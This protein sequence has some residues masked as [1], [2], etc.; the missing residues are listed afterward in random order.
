M[1]PRNRLLVDPEVQYT[2]GSRILL[3]WCLFMSGLVMFCA[4]LAMFS[5]THHKPIMESFAAGIK[6]QVPMM[7]VAALLLPV[8]LRDTLRLTNRFAGPMYR[9]RERLKSFSEGHKHVPIKFRPNDFWQPAAEEFNVVIQQFD[10][11]SRRNIE[12]EAELKRIETDG[13]RSG[14]DPSIAHEDRMSASA[15]R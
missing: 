10:A 4:S 8:F 3:H 6:S 11:L 2:I 13:R 14:T 5:E 7:V 12:L 15:V 9:L 1:R